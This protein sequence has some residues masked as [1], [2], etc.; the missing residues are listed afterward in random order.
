[1]TY[2]KCAL[3][4]KHIFTDNS[5]YYKLCCH[6]STRNSFSKNW[7]MQ[8]NDPFEFFYSDEMEEVRRK[9]LNGERVSDCDICYQKDKMGIISDRYKHTENS[10]TSNPPN[11]YMFERCMELK[12]TLWGNYCNLSCAMC[13]PVHSSE[14]AKEIKGLVDIIDVSQFEWKTSKTKLSS[15]RYQEVL[16]DINCHADLIDQITISSDGEPLLNRKMYE[17]LASIPEEEA[18]EITVAITT[19]LSNTDFL[20]YSLDDIID[21]FKHTSLRISCDHIGDKYNWIRYPGNFNRLIKNIEKYSKYI[22]GVAPAVSILNVDDLIEIKTFFNNMGLDCLNAGSYS[23]VRSPISMSCRLHKNKEELIK[24]YEKYKW[25]GP[26][27]FELYKDDKNIYTQQTK[28]IKYLN[29]LSKKRGDW[30]TLWDVV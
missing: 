20:S 23:V 5:G 3:P 17:F 12:L 25:A 10:V 15:K 4:F 29:A 6:T 28:T 21:K 14:R 18:K 30:R 24:K 13:H 27:L 11:N 26:V 8:E 16:D 9:M 22:I 7:N 1:M 19:N 2:R